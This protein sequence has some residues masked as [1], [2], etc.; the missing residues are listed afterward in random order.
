[1]DASWAS[2][3]PASFLFLLVKAVLDAVHLHDGQLVR[4]LLPLVAMTAA[5]HSTF[6][7][8]P[9]PPQQAGVSFNSPV[10][11]AF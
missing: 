4:L 9:P 1:M 11:T 8:G 6:P 2:S 5:K 3:F 10:R 7:A